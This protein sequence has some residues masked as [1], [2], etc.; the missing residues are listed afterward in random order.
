[1]SLLTADDPLQTRRTHVTSAV[2]KIPRNEMVIQCASRSFN[3]HDLPNLWLHR[4]AYGM[5]FHLI[6]LALYTIFLASLTVCAIER[7]APVTPLGM[8]EKVLNYSLNSTE[9]WFPDVHMSNPTTSVVPLTLVV[10]FA[11]I[12]AISERIL[13]WSV[14]FDLHRAEHLEGVRANVS[15]GRTRGPRL[16]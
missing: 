2:H 16:L 8:S 13:H 6:N 3:F 10:A 11:S 4:N 15:T 14:D 9:M 7:M 5:Y 1:M 12:H